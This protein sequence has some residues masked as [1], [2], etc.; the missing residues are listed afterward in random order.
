MC[1]NVTG[2]QMFEHQVLERSLGH[3]VAEVNHDGYVCQPSCLHGAI[4][5]IPLR[6]LVVSCF[7]SYQNL[8][9]FLDAHGREFRVH[10]AE[11]LFDGA[12][13]HARAHDIE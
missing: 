8:S 11:V 9:V 13:T 12:A 4:H 1:V 5:W 7:D 10:I 6:S 2:S 3:E